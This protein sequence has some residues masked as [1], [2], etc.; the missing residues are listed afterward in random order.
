MG[1]Y[2]LQIEASD[3]SKASF[4]QSTQK[5]CFEV[6]YQSTKEN[7]IQFVLHAQ[8]DAPPNNTE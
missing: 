4:A 7:R 8:D 5:A 2:T 1:E 6:I 3:T